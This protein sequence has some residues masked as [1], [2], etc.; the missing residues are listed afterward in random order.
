VVGVTAINL[1][2]DGKDTRGFSLPVPEPAGYISS[3]A[4]D[5]SFRRQGVAKALLRGAEEVAR[6]AGLQYVY[7]TALAKDEGAQNLYRDMGY[8]EMERQQPGTLAWL[9]VTRTVLKVLMC[10]CI[11][12]APMDCSESVQQEITSSRLP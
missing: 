12:P 5:K 3:M 9:N 8:D 2:P 7:L 10:K 1:K 4:V 11:Q 6:V